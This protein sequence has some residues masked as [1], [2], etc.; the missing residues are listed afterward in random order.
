MLTDIGT[1]F[2]RQAN[3]PYLPAYLLLNFALH[4]F[5]MHG[6]KAVLLSLA[7]LTLGHRSPTVPAL[8]R[9]LNAP[10]RPFPQHTRY[11]GGA[12]LPNHIGQTALD[13]TVRS[14]YLQWKKHY[15]LPGCAPDEKYVWF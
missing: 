8:H 13:D 11:V 5:P 12:I 14:F 6:I 2:F 9:S 4:I 10:T 15:I 1:D 7:I 3:F